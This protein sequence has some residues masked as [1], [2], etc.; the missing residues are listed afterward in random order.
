[1]FAKMRRQDKALPN[2]QAEKIVINAEYG[3][4]AT[5]CEN[6]YPYVIPVNH[7]V[8]DG[9][10]CFHC[11]PDV[12]LKLENIRRNPK[13]CFTAVGSTRVVQ[14][15][16]TSD[17]QSVVAYGIAREVVGEAKQPIFDALIYKFMPNLVTEGAAYTKVLYDKTAIFEIEVEHL[18]G[19]ASKG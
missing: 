5:I 3:S 17:F 6:G 16:F 18:T 10:I 15:K 12:G 13:V 4:L 11:A 7:V 9:K 14:E 1:M 8:V 19:K 2:E